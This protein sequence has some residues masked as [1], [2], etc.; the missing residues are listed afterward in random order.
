MISTKEKKELSKF[1]DRY[2]EIET[3]IEIM[4]KTI[5]NLAIKRDNLFDELD[6]LKQKE[7]GFMNRL[8]KKYGPSEVT[9]FKLLQIYQETDDCIEKP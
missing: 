9:P 4:Q 6:D 2:K 7:E 8:I 5:E 3:S 1:I